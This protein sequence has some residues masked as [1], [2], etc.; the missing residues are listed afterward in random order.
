MSTS[1][2]ILPSFAPTDLPSVHSYYALIYV[3]SNASNNNCCKFPVSRNI[4]N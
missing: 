4:A 2:F 3:N 1:V